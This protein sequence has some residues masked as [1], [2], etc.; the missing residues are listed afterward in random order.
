LVRPGSQKYNKCNNPNRIRFTSC[1]TCAESRESD[2]E[3][4]RTNGEK[5]RY[6]RVKKCKKSLLECVGR[7]EMYGLQEWS[8]DGLAGP[9]RDSK[10]VR[11][12]TDKGVVTPKKLRIMAG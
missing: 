11:V 6:E 10:G 8:L 2:V 1:Y 4:E 9:I 12:F 7:M 3:S 5:T